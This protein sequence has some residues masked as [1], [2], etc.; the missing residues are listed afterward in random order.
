MKLKSNNMDCWHHVL[1]KNT[2]L[3][4]YVKNVGLL[5][6]GADFRGSYD[7]FTCMDCLKQIKK[8]AGDV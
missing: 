7:W 8:Y 3:V 5:I 6:G 4:D 2:Q 1:I